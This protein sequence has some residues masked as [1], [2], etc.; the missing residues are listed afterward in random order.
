MIEG[1]TI[2]RK[3]GGPIGH[4]ALA[5]RFADSDAQVGLAR[6]A[7]VA[8]AALGGV[9]RNHVI[10]RHDAGDAFTDLNNDARALVAQNHRENTL[11]ITPLQRVRVGVAH[12][13]VRHPYKDFAFPGRGDIDLDDFEWLA[14]LE[15]YSGARFH[16]GI[17][18]LS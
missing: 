3:A 14:R 12:T 13:G 4:Q 2:V 6:Q 16:V 17:P 5:L 11:R 8:L 10:A 15:G 9:E 7:E 1:L 18:S